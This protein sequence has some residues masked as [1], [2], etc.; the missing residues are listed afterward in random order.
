[1]SDHASGLSRSDQHSASSAPTCSFLYTMEA[2]AQ[3]VNVLALRGPGNAQKIASMDI[4]RP[5]RAAG[6]T[7]SAFSAGWR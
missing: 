3:A 6:L 4:I 1:M 2:N 7:I 5:A